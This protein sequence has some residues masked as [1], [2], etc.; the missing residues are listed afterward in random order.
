MSENTYTLD[1]ILAEKKKI[2]NEF[3]R[4]LTE[5]ILNDSLRFCI[6]GVNLIH[7]D[8]IAP[9]MHPFLIDVKLDISI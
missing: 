7:Q 8:S 5:S 2:E 9:G 3:S 6:T 1:E 4:R